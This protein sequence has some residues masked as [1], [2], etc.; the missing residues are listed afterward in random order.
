MAAF[1]TLQAGLSEHISL[2]DDQNL[3]AFILLT[4]AALDLESTFH[5][6]AA[7]QPP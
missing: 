4:E 5:V 3:D 7:A 1:H 2:S 6:A